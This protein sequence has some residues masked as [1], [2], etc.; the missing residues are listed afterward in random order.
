MLT[1]NSQGVSMYDEL[2]SVQRQTGKIPEELQQEPKL[3]EFFYETWNWFQRLN[4]RRSSNGYSVNALTFEDIN[5]FFMLLQHQ[6]LE[7]ELLAIEHF[8]MAYMQ[9]QYDKQKSEQQKQQ[10]K[11]KLK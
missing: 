11:Q 3:D 10:N 6:P 2:L 5:A 8:D 7:H 1:P 9:V 4:A